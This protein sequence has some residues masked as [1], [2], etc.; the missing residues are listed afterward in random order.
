MVGFRLRF[1]AIGLASTC[2]TAIAADPPR[3]HLEVGQKLAYQT[4][5]TSEYHSGQRNGKTEKWQI[6]L[7][8]WVV[9]QYDNGSWKLI[10]REVTPDRVV[11]QKRTL[12]P[13]GRIEESDRVLNLDTLSIFVFPKLPDQPVRKRLTWT[14]GSDL[15]TLRFKVAEVEKNDSGKLLGFTVDLEREG[16]FN[17][18]YER[19]FTARMRFDATRSLWMGMDCTETQGFGIKSTYTQKGKLV[20]SERLA[21]RITGQIKQEAEQYFGAIE[22]SMELLQSIESRPQDADQLRVQA[23]QV[24]A[25][26]AKELKH[27]VF[28]GELIKRLEG[29]D[30]SASYKRER[31]ERVAAVLGKPAPDWEL[32]S[33]NDKKVHKLS[34]YRGSVV[35][36][37]FWY[38]GC[39]PCIK[40]IPQIKQ[41][42]QKFEGRPVAVLGINPYDSLRDALVVQQNM[43]L[44]YT[45]LMARELLANKYH[46]RSYPTLIIIDQQGIVRHVENGY[47]PTLFEQVSDKI[48]E[49][50]ENG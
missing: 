27:E 2:A 15:Q 11:L 35:V 17:Q 13:D 29:W 3:Y 19:Q 9:D 14:D 44:N 4:S 24:L 42:A 46:V 38:R 45:V 21:P 48:T 26:A 34:D 25:D 16:L 39:L 47:S 50:L 37:D 12:H 7:T 31:A 40:A 33:L 30:S 43:E 20:S 23:R 22:R 41:V 32:Q 36:L 5:G 1:A 10:V 18:V 49:L 8:A 28:A 6:D